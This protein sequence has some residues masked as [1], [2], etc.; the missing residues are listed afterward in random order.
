MVGWLGETAL[1][2][3]RG[4]IVGWA[5]VSF[6]NVSFGSVQPAIAPAMTLVEQPF[7]DAAFEAVGGK[8]LASR[9][10][11]NVPEVAANAAR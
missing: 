9:R 1:E 2:G 7:G 4:A 5:V 11:G 10:R 8:V 6:R 3:C